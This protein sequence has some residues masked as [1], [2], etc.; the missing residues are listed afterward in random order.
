MQRYIGRNRI[1]AFELGNE[2]DLYAGLPWYTKN[3]QGVPGRGPGWGYPTLNQ[4]YASVASVLTSAPLAGPSIG[5]LGWMPDL[6]AFLAAVP[7]IRLVSLHRY[8]M[9]GCTV[10]P[11]SPSYP[12][13]PHMLADA[14][15]Q[16]QAQDLA[17]YVLIAHARGLPVRNDEMNTV[18]C[19]NV[20]GVAETFASALWAMDASFQMASVGVDGINIH[21]A[22]GYT[23]QLFAFTHSGSRWRGMVA[24]EF[25]GLLM[26]AQ[27]VPRGAR[28]L[29]VTGAT[30]TLRAWSTRAPNGRV[31]VLLINDDT[32]HSQS[33]TLQVAGGGAAKVQQL[34]AS[35]AR[36][37]RHITLAGQSF[38]RNTTTGRLTGHLH[39]TL[40]HRSGG[41]FHA[42]L[43]AASAELLTIR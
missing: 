18:A 7:R 21:T 2:P 6:S 30:S 39:T 3:G 4:D 29:P 31:R 17:P 14:A 1:A 13:I 26:F 35:G 33:I 25:Y 40:L 37:T 24:P 42:R 27:A 38:A 11:S 20:R 43:P 28:L 10:P 34:K 16:G 36:A 41:A 15:S 22:A 12:S 23:D 9:Q 19:G 5:T 8:P 32:A